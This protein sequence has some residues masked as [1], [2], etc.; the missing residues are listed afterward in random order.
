MIRTKGELVLAND[1][2]EKKSRWYCS[3]CCQIGKNKSK[4]LFKNQIK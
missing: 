3:H 2:V 1:A 4:N